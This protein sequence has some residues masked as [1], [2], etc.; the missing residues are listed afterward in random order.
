MSPSTL[1]QKEQQF[2]QEAM[3]YEELCIAKYETYANQLT[4]QELKSLFQRLA[5][6]ERGHYEQ[7]NQIMQQYQQSQASQSGQQ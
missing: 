1:T 3:E 6:K 4:D 2:L 7:I 5:D